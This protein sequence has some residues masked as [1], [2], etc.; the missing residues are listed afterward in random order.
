MRSG[1][2]SVEQRPD[3]RICVVQSL[4]ERVEIGASE[5][6]SVK[7]K[8]QMCRRAI[9]H[10]AVSQNCWMQKKAT[11]VCRQLMLNPSNNNEKSV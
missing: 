9:T 1:E 5:L 2:S 8:R 11:T 3:T 4:A 10:Q 6:I 7:N